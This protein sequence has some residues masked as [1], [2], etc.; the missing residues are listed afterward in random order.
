MGRHAVSFPY[1][2]VKSV[3]HLADAQTIVVVAVKLA[4]DGRRWLRLRRLHA[5]QTQ[6][7][8]G[9]AAEAKRRRYAPSALSATPSER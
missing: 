1:L 4:H 9:G 3:K 2:P 7:R 8:D 6:G 5:T